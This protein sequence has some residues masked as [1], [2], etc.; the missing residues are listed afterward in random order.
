MPK[1]AAFDAAQ[2]EPA[3]IDL[4]ERHPLP[5][6]R[7]L[8]P[9]C[10]RAY[11]VVSLASTERTSL[12]IDIAPTAVAAAEALIAEQVLAGS[13]LA[14]RTTVREA[15][16][17]AT[18][19]TADLGGQFDLIYDCTFLCAIQPQQREAWARQMAALMAPV[20]RWTPPCGM[21]WCIRMAHLTG[22]GACLIGHVGATRWLSLS[23]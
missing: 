9:G 7:A 5:A 15:D 6:G 13:K 2:A 1:G 8:V 12:G 18:T 14:G 20:S 10:G 11:A 4:M 17:F 22:R 19:L 21:P 16:F 23:P 3:L